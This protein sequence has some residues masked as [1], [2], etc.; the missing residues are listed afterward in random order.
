MKKNIKITGPSKAVSNLAAEHPDLPRE[1]IEDIV[2]LLFTKANA[3][4]AFSNYILTLNKKRK[5]LISALDKSPY[6]NKLGSVHVHTRFN[7]SLTEKEMAELS[8]FCKSHKLNINDF[9]ETKTKFIPTP[10][11]RNILLSHSDDLFI[12]FYD[13]IKCE[14]SKVLHVRLSL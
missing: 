12:P 10:A 8:S 14:P 13:K 11:F 2:N 1:I 6:F 7:I 9:V 3:H 4:R 5:V